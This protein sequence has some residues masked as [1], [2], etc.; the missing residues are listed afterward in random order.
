[1]KAV[2]LAGPDDS[3][4]LKFVELP[5]PAVHSPNQ[6]LVRLKAAGINPIDIKIRNNPELFPL[7]QPYVPGFDGAGIVEEVGTDV[8]DFKIGDEVYFCKCAFHTE[9]GC[10]AEYAVVDQAVVAMKPEHLD[11]AEAAAIP[12]VLITAW[13]SLFDR[14]ALGAGQ[15]VLIQAGAGGVGHVAIQL[16]KM[17][18]AQV[19]TTVSG[20]E[21]ADFVR[22]LGAD[23]VILY[24][25]QPV[26]PTIMKLTGGKGVDVSFDTIGGS[27]LEQCIECTGHYGDVVT[28]LQ[29]VSGTNWKTARLRNHR[30]SFELMLSPS[31][32]GLTD[33]LKRQGEILRRCAERFSS[34]EL[35]IQV[36]GTFALQEAYRAQTTLEKNAP[37]GKLALLID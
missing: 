11:F 36:A 24:R 26:A 21:K 33:H 29:P 27:M 10:Y 2:V 37:T 34:G 5:K 1:M 13:E 17:L 18:G 9:Q 32:E 30:I 4:P 12:L 28:I 23:H 22:S 20:P 25:E 8:T 7:E 19:Y 35:K 6:V 3:G 15:S 14:A 16:A 31:I